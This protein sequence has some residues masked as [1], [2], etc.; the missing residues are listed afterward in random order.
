MENSKEV[1]LS[2]AR[3]P[4]RRRARR[5]IVRMRTWQ[6]LIPVLLLLLYLVCMVGLSR[7]ADLWIVALAGMPLL[8]ALALTAGCLLAYRRD[9]YA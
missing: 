7:V 6:P 9:F 3:L 4:I 5:L 2:V 8:F 1:P